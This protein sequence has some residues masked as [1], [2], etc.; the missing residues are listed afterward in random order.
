MLA[1]VIGLSGFGLL[2]KNLSSAERTFAGGFHHNALGVFAV[3]V[4]G[5]GKELAV[6]TVLNHH[7]AAAFFADH[8]GF[9]LGNLDFL[10]ALILL[11]DFKLL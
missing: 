8:V 3:R 6:T 7:F 10:V 9:F 5:A 1:A 2:R 11:S 4:A